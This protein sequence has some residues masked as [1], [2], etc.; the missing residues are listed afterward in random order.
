MNVDSLEKQ[1]L[2]L[3]EEAC[4]PFGILASPNAQDNYRRLWSR[5]SMIAGIAGLLADNQTI[6]DGLRRSILTLAEYQHE[7][8]MLPSNVLPD[9]SAPEISYGSL[10]G[11]VDATTWFIIGTCLFLL[12][13]PDQKLKEQLHPKLQKALNILDA[14]QF[15]AKGLLYTPLSGNWAD[16]YPIQGHTLY[17]NTLRLWALSLYAKLYKDDERRKQ[18]N[19][20]RERL[21][22]NFWPQ[23]A[24]ADHPA[25]YHRRAFSEVAS[26][27]LTHFSCAIDPS[28]Y[29][30]HFDTAAHAFA[31]LLG[32]ASEQQIEQILSYV[33][34][35]FIKIDAT[36]MPAFWPVITK[37]DALWQA[38]RKNYSYDFKNK[39]YHFHNGGIWPVWMGWFALSLSKSNASIAEEMLNAWTAVEDPANPDFW[40]YITSDTLEAAGKKNLCYSASGLLFLIHATQNK[41]QA[42]LNVSLI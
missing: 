19:I 27:G 13:Q 15:N 31:L 32:L 29:S 36:L 17:D 33:K 18:A 12:N 35:I 39:P 3:L 34:S 14:W 25:V 28:G 8:G 22:I 38:L 21:E 5:D 2:E 16:E 24:V 26:T 20:L 42:K 10:A 4:C 37:K 41:S 30:M 23:E 6:I 7:R 1:A 11:R 9:E 40:E